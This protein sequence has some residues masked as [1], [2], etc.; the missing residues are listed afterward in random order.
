MFDNAFTSLIEDLAQTGMLD[1]TLVLAMGEFGRTPKINPAGGRDHWPNCWPMVIA[2]G[3]VQGGRVVGESDATASE[4]KTRPVTPAEVAATVYHA[5]GI[6]LA[7]K[8][9]GPEGKQ[10]PIVD[11]GVQPIQ[12]LFT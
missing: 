1:N 9:P 12:E 6:D 4:P 2:G 3:G 7:T 11:E 10:I 5:V 8:L